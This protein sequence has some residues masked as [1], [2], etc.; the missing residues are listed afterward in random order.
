MLDKYI[1]KQIILAQIASDGGKGLND[2]LKR[3]SSS[4]PLANLYFKKG[5]ETK[6]H[7]IIN[8]IRAIQRNPASGFYYSVKVDRTLYSGAHVFIVY[9]N[10]KLHNN[11][12]QI[13]FHT[14]SNMWRYVN[15]HCVTRWKK[16]YSSKEATI[17]LAYYV[18]G[19]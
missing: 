14:Y 9:F 5:Y 4:V 16:K 17:K 19:D 18:F 6:D 2:V 3:I 12:Y 10:F 15:R 1:S 13:S 8:A 7:C 11:A